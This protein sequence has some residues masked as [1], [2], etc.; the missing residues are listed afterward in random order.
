MFVYILLL[1]II[2]LCLYLFPRQKE[3]FDSELV[4]RNIPVDE[5]TQIR[6]KIL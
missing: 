4:V 2:G 1:V 6:K 5:N 3:H